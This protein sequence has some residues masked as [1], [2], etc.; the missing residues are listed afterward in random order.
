VLAPFAL[1]EALVAGQRATI[2]AHAA[3][4]LLFLG[5]CG[6]ALGYFLWTF[7]L[8]RLSPTQLM[9][10]INVN[11]M[12]ATILG[13]V[14]LNEHITLVFVVAFGLVLAGVGVVNWPRRATAVAALDDPL[15][16]PSG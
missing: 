10:Y 11:P 4:L 1:G 9:V 7:G 2:D 6:G 15:P 16:A 12:T 5:V 3:L 13:A 14:L 8:S